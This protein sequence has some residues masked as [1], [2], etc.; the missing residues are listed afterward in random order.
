G[1]ISAFGLSWSAAPGSQASRGVRRAQGAGAPGNNPQCPRADARSPHARSSS[2][3]GP[4][5]WP[6]R[7]AA[8]QC[9]AADEGRAF[10][11]LPGC[12]TCIATLA[13][14]KQL[15]SSLFCRFGARLGVLARQHR[16]EEL[17]G[18]APFH[19]RDVLRGAGGDDLAAAIAAFRAEV[20][21][22]V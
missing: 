21:D 12:Y 20:D 6:A 22:P 2:C 13:P 14:P 19:P 4:F 5:S 9:R 1:V 7:P 16:R 10:G 8:A 11:R 3:S 15:A 17:S 18:V